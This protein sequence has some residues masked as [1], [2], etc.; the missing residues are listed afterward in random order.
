MPAADE[1]RNPLATT[2]SKL[3]DTV[4]IRELGVPFWVHTSAQTVSEQGIGG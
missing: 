4:D 1:R 2:T 3:V